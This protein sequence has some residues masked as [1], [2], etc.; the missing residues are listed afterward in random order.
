LCLL[1]FGVETRELL[2]V[3][4]YCEAFIAT[5]GLY[6]GTERNND[7]GEKLVQMFSFMLAHLEA[8]CIHAACLDM[9]Q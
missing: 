9:K 6:S 7:L 3:R 1:S 8:L 2:A 4:R 5:K